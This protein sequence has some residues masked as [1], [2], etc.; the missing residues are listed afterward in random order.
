MPVENRTAMPAPGNSKL[1][2]RR[3][4]VYTVQVETKFNI[5]VIYL[6]MINI[7]SINMCKQTTRQQ[8]R[9][10]V[11]GM[12]HH[13]TGNST[14]EIAIME[15]SD[16][17]PVLRDYPSWHFNLSH[18]HGMGVCAIS[19]IPVGVDI[20]RITTRP[21]WHSIAAEWFTPG[22]QKYLDSSGLDALRVFHHIW[23]RKESWLKLHGRSVWDIQSAPECLGEI[24]GL[25]TFESAAT[26]QFSLSV[27]ALT[28][29]QMEIELLTEFR[30]TE[31][32][33]SHVILPPCQSGGG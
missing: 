14:A 16:G 27:R 11:G 24:P 29:K 33:F 22:E 13:L 15:G 5:D 2:F 31:I 21:S 28:E 10:L 6:G 8:T 12:L 4:I 30:Q 32:R 26:P 18:S 7:S 17:K 1:F 9:S 20:E 3:Q 23:T 25:Y 19:M